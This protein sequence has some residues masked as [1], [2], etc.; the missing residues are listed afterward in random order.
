[1]ITEIDFRVKGEGR[2]KLAY[3]IG[4]LLGMPCIILS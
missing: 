3:A 4:E 2:K 1:M